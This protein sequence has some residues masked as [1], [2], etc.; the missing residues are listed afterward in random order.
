MKRVKKVQLQLNTETV[1]HL[2]IRVVDAEKLRYAAGGCS[3]SS[4]GA[5]HS[6]AACK[7]D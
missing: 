1:Q 7:Q 2:N 6:S 3:D 4:C 5:A